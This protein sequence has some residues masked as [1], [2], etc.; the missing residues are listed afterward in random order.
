MVRAKQ[1]I[2]QGED[3][4]YDRDI[5]HII[6][7]AVWW[8][9]QA[10]DNKMLIGTTWKQCLFQLFSGGWHWAKRCSH[11][12]AGKCWC[13]EI[14]WVLCLE[15][16]SCVTTQFKGLEAM[17]IHTTPWPTVNGKGLWQRFS[18]NSMDVFKRCPTSGSLTQPVKVMGRYSKVEETKI[19]Y[20]QLNLSW[21]IISQ[22]AARPVPR[23]NFVDLR[24]KSSSL[25]QMI[26]CCWLLFVVCC[27]L[28]GIR[29]CCLLLV[30]VSCLLFVACC[31]CVFACWHVC[32]IVTASTG[33][34]AS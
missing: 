25:N 7:R 5:R 29:Y 27:P 28:F 33:Q 21:H 10:L 2:C 30:V 16:L 4:S 11:K 26:L 17:H 34:T 3:V 8:G 22:W 32:H 1:K 15:I 18:P 13:E 23:F 24:E 19:Q 20:P 31:L 14:L 6:R 9:G 12:S